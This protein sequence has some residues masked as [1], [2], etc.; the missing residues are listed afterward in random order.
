MTTFSSRIIREHLEHSSGLAVYGCPPKAERGTFP[1]A[2]GESSRNPSALRPWRRPRHAS[3]APRLGAPPPGPRHPATRPG[4]RTP[5]GHVSRVPRLSQCGGC[6]ALRPP[7]AVRTP[8]GGGGSRSSSGQSPWSARV[9]GSKARLV[10][11]EPE[12]GSCC[13]GTMVGHLSEGAIAVRRRLRA[14]RG[15]GWLWALGPCG[16]RRGREHRSR[17]DSGGWGGTTG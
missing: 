4:T 6:S 16:W 12:R 7:R 1:R 15:P 8:G 2:R 11:G 9:P 13:G 3:R 14:G 10:L 5:V 17:S